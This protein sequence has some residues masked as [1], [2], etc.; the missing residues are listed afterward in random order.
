MKSSQTIL[1]SMIII[2]ILF[3]SGCT[4]SPPNQ[5]NTNT[6]NTY[7]N[8]EIGLQDN[9]TATSTGGEFSLLDDNIMVNIPSGALTTT[10]NITLETI[11]DPIDDQDLIMFSCINFGPDGTTFQHPIDIIIRYN[12]TTI[13]AGVE[14]SDIKIY[15]LTGNAWEP[16]EDSF[17]N[18]A[19]HWAVA[20][21][22]HFSKMGCAASAPPQQNTNDTEDDDQENG[23]NNSAQYWF[24]ANLHYYSITAP[25]SELFGSTRYSVGV[26][27]YWKPVSYMQYYEIKFDFKGNQPED[28][29]WHCE[30][31]EQGKSSCTKNPYPINEGYIYHLGGNPEIKGFLSTIT[32]GDWTATKIDPDTGEKTVTVYGRSWPQGNDGY[33]F[34]GVNDVVEEYEELSAIDIGVIVSNME[35]FVKEYVNNWEIWVRGVTETQT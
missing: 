29:A 27:A 26:S 2:L 9:F 21:V 34:F 18:I 13:P 32:T 3:I 35:T 6:N 19:M 16:I 4:E 28:Y 22:T 33:N 5:N 7:Y 31:R 11:E 12:T 1:S 8:Y 17:A 15:L 10:T 24:K 14:E 30:F 23:E 25:T 20:S